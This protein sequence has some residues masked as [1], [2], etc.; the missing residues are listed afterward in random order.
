MTATDPQL[1]PTSRRRLL[2]GLGAATLA[3]GL[4]YLANEHVWDL[5]VFEVGGLDPTTRLGHAVHF[6]LYDTAKIMLLIV[7]LIFAISMARASVPPERIRDII[8]RRHVATGF[9]LAAAFGALTPFC[10]CSSVPLF[11]G[12]VAAGV[13]LGITLTFLITSPLIN[14]VG[15]VMLA[16]MVGWEIAAMYVA[17]GMAMAVVAGVV[18]S[19]FDL[20]RFIDPMV[21]EVAAPPPTDEHGRIALSDRIDAARTETIE[22]TRTV[23]PYVLVG[24]AVGAGIH[25]WVPADFFANT[26]IADSLWSVPAATVAGI[27]L[28]ANVAGVVPLVEAVYAKGLGL[29]TA[30]SFM[31][32]IVAL[33][34]PALVLL[35]RVMRLPLLAIFT[36]VVTLGIVGIGFI[37]DLIV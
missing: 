25:G 11:I 4:L 29:G 17:T 31:M 27:P 6:F 14:Q 16:G 33:S 36:G 15:V 7:G 13:P 22:I 9:L 34:L 28:Y 19:R 20:E 30:M 35:K 1:Q 2:A 26:G 21:S 12:F 18:L 32:S 3:W 23:W 5:L 37:F 8:S 24:I 10:S